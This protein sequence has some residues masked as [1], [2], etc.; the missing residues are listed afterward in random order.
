MLI[1][2]S[3]SESHPRPCIIFIVSKMRILKPD[4]VANIYNPETDKEAEA[5][6]LI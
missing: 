2:R 4:M 5:R 1:T 3:A 6:E